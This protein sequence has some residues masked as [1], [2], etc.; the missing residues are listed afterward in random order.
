MEKVEQIG[1]H[2]PISTIQAPICR[3]WIALEYMFDLYLLWHWIEEVGGIHE[4]QGLSEQCGN[5]PH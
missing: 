2:G 1:S 3:A 4:G 5:G